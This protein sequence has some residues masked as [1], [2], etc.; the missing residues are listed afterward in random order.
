M[1]DPEGTRIGDAERQQ[2]IDVLSKATGEGRLTL[3]EFADR[4][5]EVYAARTRDELE[6]VVADLPTAVRRP[7]EPA[8]GAQ[9]TPATPRSGAPE[10]TA[11]GGRPGGRRRFV[12][13]MGGSRPRGRWRASERITAFAFWG[14]VTLDLRQALIESPTLDITA[15]AIMGGVTVIVP[16][17]IPVEL[18]GFVLMGGA[19]D[20]TRPGRPIE[21]A[22]AVRVRAR[23]LWGGV[24]AFTRRERGAGS[25]GSAE[26]EWFDQLTS[27][28]RHHARRTMKHAMRHGVPT[29]PMPPMP[30]LPGGR[31][32]DDLI[33]P[34]PW[35]GRDRDREHAR[36]R[37]DGHAGDAES[38]AGSARTGTSNTHQPEPSTAQGATGSMRDTGPATPTATAAGDA[39]ARE[40]SPGT[41]HVG[42]GPGGGTVTLLVTDIC[43]STEMA[44]RLGDQRWL[45]VLQAHNALVR[46]QIHR[47]HGTEVKA[48][49]DGFLVTFTSARQ[50]VLS[51]IGIQRAMSEYRRAHSE[52]QV[53]VRVGIHTG[54]V[55]EDHGDVIG[56]NVIL[57][58]R[59][60]DAAAPGEILVSSLTKDLTDAGGDLGY[61]EGREAELKG[62][63]RA[64]RVHAVAWT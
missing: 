7:T 43:R 13:I 55:V 29:P 57:A 49:G 34:M 40:P 39:A 26:G 44:S 35:E 19:S 24:K 16:E 32:L 54:E 3:D 62:V 64:W 36:A 22:P 6:R 1:A 48:Q 51:A 17:G 33:P 10:S 2:V 25:A 42:A 50:A 53:E 31:S 21:G 30:R 8:R 41:P 60:A 28:A 20:H 45:G 4:A 56:Q 58:V 52:H 61:D 18:D 15:W 23:G 11:G 59:I 46:D 37:A 38:Q 27:D 47:H 5:G 9:A 63:S 12:A 14:G